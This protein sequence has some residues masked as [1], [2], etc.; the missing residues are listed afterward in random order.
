MLPISLDY[1]KIEKILDFFTRKAAIYWK[2]FH[3]VRLWSNDKTKNLLES[4]INLKEFT[5]FITFKADP[6]MLCMQNF[7]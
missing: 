1:I 3:F 5:Y 7:G 4:F 2:G 6:S